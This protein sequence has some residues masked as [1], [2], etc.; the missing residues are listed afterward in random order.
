MLTAI[1]Y[2][3]WD[4]GLEVGHAVRT[5]EEC[6]VDASEDFFFRVAMLDA[7]LI[8]GSSALFAKLIEKYKAAYIEGKRQEFLDD[9]LEQRA[10]RETQ[11]GRHTY[12]LE[13][14]IKESCG[15]FRDIQSMVWTA[16]VVFGLK[17]LTSLQEAGLLSQEEL[18]KFEEAQDYLVR[19]RNRLHYLSG[20]KN[21]QLFFEHQ[22]EM[23]GGLRF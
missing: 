8:A 15:G 12:L 21:D 4:A 19:I 18:K 23:A 22:E 3:L 11:Y 17:D 20:R 6:M 2:P 13:P 16:Q 9:M 7:R 14:H 1:L 5:L 10:K